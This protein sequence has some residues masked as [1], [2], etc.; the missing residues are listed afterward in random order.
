MPRSPLLL[1]LLLAACSDDA[2]DTAADPPAATSDTGD[3]PTTGDAPPAPEDPPTEEAALAAWL[4]AGHYKGWPSESGL[5]PSTGPHFGDVRTFVNPT[6]HDSLEA[7]NAAHPKGAATVK[8]LY[9]GGVELK[10]W[11]VII[12]GFDN[13]TMQAAGDGWYWYESYDGSVYASSFGAGLCV[14][15]HAASH[16]DFKDHVLTPFPLQ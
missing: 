3:A 4:A 1:A 14:G 11:S 7:G 9:G 6:L 12:K 10:G 5:H 13:S 16:P 8:E 2:A 15:C